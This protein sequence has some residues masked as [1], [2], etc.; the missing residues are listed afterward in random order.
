MKAMKK[1]LLALAAACAV[2][3]AVAQQSA[4]RSADGAVR[5]RQASGGNA[6]AAG[7]PP[8]IVLGAKRQTGTDWVRPAEGEL[9]VGTAQGSQTVRV[10]PR[11]TD[12][13]LNRGAAVAAP[14]IVRNG[15]TSRWIPKSQACPAYYSGAITWEEE[16]IAT[17]NSS[18]TATGAVRNRVDSCTAIVETRWVAQNGGCPVGH[19]GSNTWEAEER[20]VGGGGW[21]STGATRSHNNTCTAPPPDPEPPAMCVTGVSETFRGP[22]ANAAFPNYPP[23]PRACTASNRGTFAVMGWN[24]KQFNEQCG[25]LAT[26]QCTG[27][28]WK[29][30][31]GR[32]TTCDAGHSAYPPALVGDFGL[33][34]E[35]AALTQ[36]AY[37]PG[38]NGEVAWNGRA[39][40]DNAVVSYG[41][42]KFPE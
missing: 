36:Q 16:E 35:I 3:P 2:L 24:K 6:G 4:Q 26:A 21:M 40:G 23:P 10:N 18:W 38:Y 11:G 33:M 32:T 7:Q 8:I 1:T 25:W 22:T 37:T 15:A 17:I 29:I 19:S 39:P 12:V 31:G 5:V 28:G 27:Q 13:V 20:R 42:E 34:M 14:T 9:A 41:C 30:Y